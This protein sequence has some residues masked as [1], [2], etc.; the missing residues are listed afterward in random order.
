MVILSVLDQIHNLAAFVT[1][2]ARHALAWSIGGGR[3]LS[4]CHLGIRVIPIE[5]TRL[6]C[7]RG[8]QSEFGITVI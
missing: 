7:E 6:R 2:H 8:Y 3:W 1:N 4:G 5:T